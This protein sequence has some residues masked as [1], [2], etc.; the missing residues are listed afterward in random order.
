MKLNSDACY[1]LSKSIDSFEIYSYQFNV[2]I[3]GL[4]LVAERESSKQ[5]ANLCLQLFR[6]IGVKEIS[7]NDINITH[8]N[9]FPQMALNKK[10]Y[11]YQTTNHMVNT[12]VL[13]NFLNVRAIFYHLSFW[14]FSILL[15]PLVFTHQNLISPKSH[16]SLKV[17]M[18]LMLLITDQ[19]LTQTQNN[20]NWITHQLNFFFPVVFPRVQF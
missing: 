3:T 16:L 13:P 12:L 20:S 2:K 14:S 8:P 1:R 17:K 15:L 4:L 10:F 5:M 9:Q 18:R 19:F 6:Q 7:I 11:L